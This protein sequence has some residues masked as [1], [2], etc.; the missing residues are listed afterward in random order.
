MQL[1]RLQIIRTMP[2]DYGELELLVDQ[3]LV[4]VVLMALLIITVRVGVIRIS[5]EV[6]LVTVEANPAII[7]VILVAIEVTVTV[8]TIGS[9]FFI[10]ICLNQTYETQSPL[11]QTPMPSDKR[12]KV[13]LVQ[14]MFS[15][16]TSALITKTIVT[17]FDV[18]KTYLQVF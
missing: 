15:S 11:C 9:P 1:L 2:S 16:G 18:I 6:V 17:P 5:I 12:E 14:R 3:V 13:P 10:S 7:G 8:T 4:R